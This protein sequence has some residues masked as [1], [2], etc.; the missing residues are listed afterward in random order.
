MAL[1]N[2]GYVELDQARDTWINFNA[3]LKENAFVI[4][5]KLLTITII[6][7]NFFTVVDR[8]YKNTFLM[9][10]PQLLMDLLSDEEMQETVKNNILEGIEQKVILLGSMPGASCK[11]IGFRIGT[12]FRDVFGISYENA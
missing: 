3:L 6:F 4:F 7:T 8:L 10:V 12:I 9:S 5:G 2:T 11:S 1:I